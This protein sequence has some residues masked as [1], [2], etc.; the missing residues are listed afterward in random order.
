MRGKSVRRSV[1]A[2]G[3]GEW[4]RRF[5][6]GCAGDGD[7]RLAD[8][9]HLFE[10]CGEAFLEVGAFILLEKVRQKAETYYG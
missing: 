5:Q 3:F 8:I 4:T 2:F 1:G 6:G 10:F 7:G 9:F